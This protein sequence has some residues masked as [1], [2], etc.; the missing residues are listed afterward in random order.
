MPIHGADIPAL[1]S[2]PLFKISTQTD[3]LGQNQKMRVEIISV[4][5]SLTLKGFMI[6]ARSLQDGRILG[7]F[8]PPQDRL[9]KI[10]ECGNIGSTAT[11]S[12]TEQKRSVVLEWNSPTDFIGDIVFKYAY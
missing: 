8:S 10:I 11:H 3:I 12:S 4:I 7:E 1:S 5:N 2:E 9:T 6:Q